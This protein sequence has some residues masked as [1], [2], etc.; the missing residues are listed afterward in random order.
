MTIRPAESRVLPFTRTDMT[1]L[2]VV[3]RNFVNAPKKIQTWA[4]TDALLTLRRL[5]SYIY[6]A[7]ILDVSRPHTTTQ[8]SR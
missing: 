2:I 8:H 4:T 1:K 3:F 6:G 5:M 7:P